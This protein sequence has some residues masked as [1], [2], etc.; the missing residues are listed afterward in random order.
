MAFDALVVGCQSDQPHPAL[1][2]FSAL[3]L[4]FMQP[5][6]LLGN[7]GC[8]FANS[9]GAVFSWGSPPPVAFD[10][11]VDCRQ[12]DQPRLALA[13]FS[14]LRLVIMQPQVLLRGEGRLCRRRMTQSAPSGAG[15][16]FRPPGCSLGLLPCSFLSLSGLDVDDASFF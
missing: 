3:H 2:V 5:Q 16:F 8:L 1:A 12:L 13:V 11:F 10:L 14:A 4:V 7:T 6:V 9:L 15:G